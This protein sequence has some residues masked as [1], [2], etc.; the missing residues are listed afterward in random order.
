MAKRAP[1]DFPPVHPGQMLEEEFLLPLGMS[2]AGLAS[3]VAMP[4]EPLQAFVAGKQAVSGEIAMRLGRYFGTG[5]EFWFNLQN[6]YALEV[7]RDEWE[8]RV[9]AE[10]APRAA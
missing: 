9:E 5:P 1:R 2:L 8:D 10:V 3:A 4:V 6:R 7:A